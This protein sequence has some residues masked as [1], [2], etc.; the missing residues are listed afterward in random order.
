MLGPIRES[1][2]P[3]PMTNRTATAS[4]Y[5]GG[6]PERNASSGSA[7]L[8]RLSRSTDESSADHASTLSSVGAA[9]MFDG[10]TVEQ[11]GAE[12]PEG[13]TAMADPVLLL[14][15]ELRHRPVPADGQEDRVV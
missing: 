8:S 15:I 7:R 6:R 1:A 2:T 12:R 11:Q 4:T 13:P 14:R 3:T 10:S 5:A 9:P